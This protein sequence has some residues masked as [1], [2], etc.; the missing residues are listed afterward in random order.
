VPGSHTPP[1][2]THPFGHVDDWHSPAALH[3]SLPGQATHCV[4]LTP[5]AP[6]VV[7]ERQLPLEQHPWH[8]AG[9]H[10]PPSPP[11]STHLPLEQLW[12]GTQTAQARP[13]LPQALDCRPG[14]QT[15]AE[16]QQPVQLDAR[17]DG[18]PESHEGATPRSTPNT[19]AAAR[20]RK[21]CMGPTIM[22]RKG[23]R[24]Q[25]IPF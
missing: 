24:P 3:V 15:P 19:K 10:G 25:K 22:L 4:P 17:H 18:L 5:H 7:P 9:L 20:G 21:P 14:R 1:V 6:V 23:G 16:V 2:S 12:P 13:S 11:P 8:V